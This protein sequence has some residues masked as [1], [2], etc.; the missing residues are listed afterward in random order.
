MP[1][2]H[3]LRHEMGVI[4]L[5]AQALWRALDALPANED[6]MQAALDGLSQQER[7]QMATYL[8]TMAQRCGQIA[9]RARWLKSQLT[10]GIGPG[11]L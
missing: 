5:Q 8:G 3:D 10:H 7:Q 6:T 11:G 2:R 4:T 9:E 1:L